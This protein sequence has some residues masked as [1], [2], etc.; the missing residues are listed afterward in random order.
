[1][2]TIPNLDADNLV[3]FYVVATEKSLTA[4]AEKLFLT[5]PAITYRIK[6]LE[7]YTR[8]KLVD[9]KK[10][11]VILTPSGQEVYKY[12]R[13]IYQQL[14][15]ADRFIKSIRESNLRVG[16]ASIYNNLV[17][18]ALNA[19]FEE[20]QPE[21]KLTIESGNS[22]DMVQ[23]VA[24]ARLD[25]AIVPHFNYSVNKLKSVEISQP[26]KLFC[27]AGRD[28]KVLKEPLSWRD[29]N[30]YPLVSGPPTSAV[31]RIVMDRFKSE[32]IDV[33]PLAAEVDNI[34]WCINLV[35]HGKGLSF[36]FM[37]EI[38][39]QIKSGRLKLVQLTEDLYISAD[40]VM[41]QDLFMNPIINRFIAMVKEAFG[42]KPGNN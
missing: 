32:G 8:V 24:D 23:S 39:P 16:V 22:F 15:S 42:S 40:A 28:Q 11:Q 4:A 31:R 19:I 36:A 21:V 34:D 9:V 2:E 38:E 26:I 27:I 6:T 33:K 5:Q 25:L 7:E 17:S 30:D 10:H 18:P 1:M 14:V 29:L 35:E 12:A 3:I 37:S 13:E 20:P 41:S